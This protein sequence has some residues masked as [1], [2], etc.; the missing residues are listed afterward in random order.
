MRVKVESGQGLNLLTPSVMR[1]ARY[2]IVGNQ[3]Q[4]Q[5]NGRRQACRYFAIYIVHATR[6]MVAPMHPARVGLHI[7]TC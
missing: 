3:R 6:Y 2:I 4:L 1:R 7:F 5:G